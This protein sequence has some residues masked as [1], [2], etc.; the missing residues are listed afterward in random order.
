MLLCTVVK[1]GI[2]YYLRFKS[3]KIRRYNFHKFDISRQFSIEYY[4]CYYIPLQSQ[5]WAGVAIQTLLAPAWNN[6]SVQLVGKEA[7]R[8]GRNRTYLRDRYGNQTILLRPLGR[9]IL[10]SHLEKKCSKFRAGEAFVSVSI[11]LSMRCLKRNGS[12]QLEKFQTFL[13]FSKSIWG[14]IH[15]T[16]KEADIL[17]HWQCIFMQ[18]LFKLS[19]IQLDLNDSVLSLSFSRLM[20]K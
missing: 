4:F 7:N 13:T 6:K 19:T 20:D 12:Q 2:Y 5:G 17:I 3:Y 9:Q 10:G 14:S 18:L 16:S 8:G 15:A 1:D 11:K